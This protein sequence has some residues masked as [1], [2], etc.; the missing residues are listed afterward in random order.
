MEALIVVAV[1]L[2]S[3][4]L[5]KYVYPLYGA[6]GTQVAVFGVAFMFSA[7][8]YTAQLNPSVMEILVS[9]GQVLLLAVGVY[10]VLLKRIGFQSGKSMV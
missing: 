10:E 2:L 9:A 3:Q 6:I 5:K 7:I 1:A 8:Y 4:V